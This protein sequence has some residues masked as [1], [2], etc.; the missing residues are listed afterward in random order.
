M[1]DM[2]VLA[3]ETHT[4]LC[5]AVLQPPA[6]CS[7]I[8]HHLM[9]TEDFDPHPLL[10]EVMRRPASRT[11]I[12]IMLNLGVSVD[13][14][15]SI[16][17]A[18]LLCAASANNKTAVGDLLSAVSNVC[19][20][21]ATGT[22][23]L[24]VAAQAGDAELVGLL[25]RRGAVV[26]QTNNAGRTPL[27]DAVTAA[28]YQTVAFLLRRGSNTRAT[29]NDGQTALHM[30][31]Q[32]NGKPSF[33]L[34]N[35]L[36]DYGVSLAQQ[37]NN[38]RT[39]LHYAA[40]KQPQHTDTVRVLIQRHH[41]QQGKLRQLVGPSAR[42][43]INMRDRDGRTALYEAKR[44]GNVDIYKSLVDAGGDPFIRPNVFQHGHS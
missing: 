31:V 35:M 15:D 13:Y 9:A 18:A 23:A 30:A 29:D 14:P 39:A 5:W 33:P 25:L 22:T 34:L 3:G 19:H 24:H 43:V 40:A 38:G 37:D 1:I 28:K 26:S 11:A 32:R 12:Q 27:H 42:K 6:I 36:F 10:L 16:K 44:A 7:E 17:N 8:L 41:K 2:L 21:N 20:M 4:A